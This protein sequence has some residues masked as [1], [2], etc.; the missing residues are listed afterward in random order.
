MPESTSCPHCN[1]PIAIEDEGCTCCAASLDEL[2]GNDSADSLIHNSLMYE[3]YQIPYL[4]EYLL[5]MGLIKRADLETAL[6]IQEEQVKGSQR[7]LLG[8]ILIEQGYIDQNSLNQ[9]IL[10]QL[11]SLGSALEISEKN[12]EGSGKVMGLQTNVK[13]DQLIISAD[14]T[15]EAISIITRSGSKEQVLE[16]LVK[17]FQDAPYVSAILLHEAAGFR[18]VS[19]SANHPLPKLPD[20]L[21]VHQDRLDMYL[22]LINPF[23][24]FAMEDSPDLPGELMELVNLLSEKYLAI[25]PVTVDSH[26][27]AMI[28]CSTNHSEEINISNLQ[29]YIDITKLFSQTLEGFSHADIMGRR[30]SVMRSLEA[31]NQTIAQETDLERLYQVIHEQISKVVGEVDLVIALYD[32][33][34][35]SIN[36]PY[37]CEDKQLISVPTFPLGEGLTSVIINTGQPLM[38]LENADIHAEEMGAKIIG[39]P[40]KSFL[41]VPLIVAGEVFGALIVQDTSSEY[42]FDDEDQNFLT[43]LA[44]QVAISIRNLSMLNEIHAKAHRNRI[45]SEITAKFWTSSDV[46]TIMRTAILELGRTLKASKGLIQLKMPEIEVDNMDIESS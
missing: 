10:E 21:A 16:G 28:I 32:Q 33:G 23:L 22:N 35:E 25:L 4:G 6:A 31:I 41:G 12:I 46:D 42:R 14:L 37:A 9:I 27:V 8:Q 11:L 29:V 3:E 40:A 2:A 45:V 30:L 44:S 17:V 18:V 13:P 19:P 24:I 26:T 34:E 15:S 36:F 1:Q 20:R 7:Q 43:L 39:K 5:Q 38:L